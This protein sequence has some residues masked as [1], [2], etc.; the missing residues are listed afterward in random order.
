MSGWEKC[1]GGWRYPLPESDETLSI[2]VFVSTR[3]LAV[4]GVE[5]CNRSVVAAGAP[6][7]PQEAAP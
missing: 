3:M 6:P 5:T 1:P 4:F 7:L 2:W